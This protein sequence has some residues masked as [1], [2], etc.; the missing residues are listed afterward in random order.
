MNNIDCFEKYEEMFG[1][2]ITF[3]FEMPTNKTPEDFMKAIHECIEKKE[4]Y[5]PKKYGFDFEDSVIV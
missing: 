1:E 4:R 2:S 3:P 5:D